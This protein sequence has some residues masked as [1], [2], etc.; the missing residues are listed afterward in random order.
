MSKSNI[1]QIAR[2]KMK[3]GNNCCQ[4]VLL[5]AQT[6]W[7]IPVGEDILAAASLFGEGMGSGCSC[8]ALTGM[9]MAAGIMNK[10]HPHLGGAKLEQTLHDQFKHEFGSTCCRV[11]KKKRSVI[12]KIGNNACIELTGRAAELL[13]AAWEGVTNESAADIDNNSHPQ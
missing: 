8:G 6:A 9:I 1:S 12:K 5:A 11:I 10:Y 4:S 3:S 13:F 7:N 2:V